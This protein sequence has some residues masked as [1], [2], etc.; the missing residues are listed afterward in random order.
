MIITETKLR[1]LIR[2]ILIE[3]M[4]RRSFTKLL[5]GGLTGLALSSLSSSADANTKINDLFDLKKKVADKIKQKGGNDADN[6]LA[7]LDGVFNELM[8]KADEN[9]SSNDIMQICIDNLGFSYHIDFN[10]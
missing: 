2:E 9:L 7:A 8:S 4:S 6:Q 3:S 1:R 5:G 10:F